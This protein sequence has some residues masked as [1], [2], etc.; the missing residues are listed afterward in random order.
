MFSACVLFAK[1]A[2]KSIDE[3]FSNGVLFAKNL[4]ESIDEM[5]ITEH[6][7]SVLFDAFS[8][9]FEQMPRSHT[10]SSDY[11]YWCLYSMPTRIRHQM[12]S[13]IETQIINIL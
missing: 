4:L 11:K 8:V 5:Q 9:T 13:T 7:Y 1:N 10:A 3:M 2:L 12:T 6:G